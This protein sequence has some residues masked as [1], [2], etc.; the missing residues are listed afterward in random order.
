MRE[1]GK[2]RQP[3]A[4][5]EGVDAGVLEEGDAVVVGRGDRGIVFERVA[6]DGGEVVAFVD[7]LE[8]CGGGVDVVIGE[9]DAAGRG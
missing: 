4:L 2:L 8:D 6:R 7:V 5:G 1:P 9:L 3:E